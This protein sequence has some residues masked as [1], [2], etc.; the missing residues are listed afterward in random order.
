MWRITMENNSIYYF[1]K[2][3]LINFKLNSFSWL[4]IKIIT[5]TKFN[6]FYL[7]KIISYKYFCFKTRLISDLF[8]Y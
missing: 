7:I 1:I 5:N 8:Q 2:S 4:N 3:T 6:F